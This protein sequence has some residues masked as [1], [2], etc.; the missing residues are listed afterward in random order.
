MKRKNCFFAGMFGL[1]LLWGCPAG[2]SEPIE[3][4]D[5]SLVNNGSDAGETHEGNATSDAGGETIPD[6]SS[7]EDAGQPEEPTT[8]VADAGSE[9]TVRPPA[10]QDAG[11][12]LTRC[13]AADLIYYAEPRDSSGNCTDAC[14]GST[15]EFVGRVYNP[16]SNAIEFTTSNTCIVQQFA[17]ER[18]DMAATTPTTNAPVCGMAITT[19]SIE[20][21]TSKEQS[22]G[23]V[24]G[25]D[26]GN[27]KLT[28]TFSSF[29]TNNSISINPNGAEAT[30]TFSVP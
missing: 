27:W 5:S 29:A 2:D 11:T 3:P 22:S 20:P 15:L 17:W 28:V 13:T 9:E 25:V 10:T 26:T 12:D 4:G 16:C 23:P 8:P 18:S 1:A 30:A 19:H 24:N 7:G 21:L 6:N 14:D